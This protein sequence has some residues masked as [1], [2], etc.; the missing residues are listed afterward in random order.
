MK[1]AVVW[2]YGH[3]SHAGSKAPS[4]AIAFLL[5]DGYRPIVFHEIRV[6]KYFIFPFDFLRAYFSVERGSRVVF[7]FPVHS[8]S[9]FRVVLRLASC[10]A[11]KG[12]DR[13]AL[14]H[15]VNFGRD[16]AG[17][18]A[19]QNLRQLACFSSL[20]VHSTQMEELLRRNG[21]DIPCRVLGLFDYRADALN[22]KP[23]VNAPEVVFA[24]NLS[25]SAFLR[26]L[27]GA[28]SGSLHF[29]LYGAG[30]ESLPG[31]EG[32]SYKGKF[33][34]DDLSSL[35][36]SYGLVWDGD[37]ISRC[38]GPFGE[39]LKYNSP[40]KA[41]LYVCAGL[42]LIVPSGSAVAD[43]VTS[44]GIGLAVDSLE[45]L[46]ETLSGV[47]DARYSAMKAACKAYASRLLQGGSL[48]DSLK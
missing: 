4:D 13:V 5:E 43:I 22:V 25:K 27:G 3:L 23:R 26:K 1:Y 31:I 7:Q 21:C 18:R 35:E 37:E 32:V 34:P 33:T 12:V 9:T 36:G 42:P 30:G 44:S 16:F 6:L 45:S 2:N 40:H 28:V 47:S 41:S 48:R 17:V 15:D 19:E 29:N 46:Q 11:R 24:G 20:I 38:S 8:G 14:V 39:Y 10:L